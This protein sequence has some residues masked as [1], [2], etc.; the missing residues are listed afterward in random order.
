[1]IARSHLVGRVFLILPLVLASCGSLTDCDQ[2][3][4]CTVYRCSFESLRDLRRWDGLTVEDLRD[5][6]PPGGGRR[7][8]LVAG[9]CATPTAT[10]SLAP[11]DVDRMLSVEC[12]CKVLRFH[13]KV[14]LCVGESQV[15]CVGFEARDTAWTHYACEHAILCPA[16]SSLTVFLTAGGFSGQEMLVDRLEVYRVDCDCD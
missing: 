4:D 6:H 11:A 3:R 13:G 5:D 10:L 14:G 12:Y 9:G 7:S 8:V 2:Q 16:E 15:D 1:L